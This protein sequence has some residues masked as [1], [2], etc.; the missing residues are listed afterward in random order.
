[1][2]MLC[3]GRKVSQV[4]TGPAGAETAPGGTTGQVQYNNAGAFG[5]TPKLTIGADAVNAAADTATPSGGSAAAFLQLGTTAGFGIYFGS[6]APT[7]SAAQGSIYLRTNGTTINNRAY[8][9]TGGT[10]WTG[11]GT[12]I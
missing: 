11:I 6:G 8:L 7:V 5:G 10:T 9:N 4:P 12:L 1:M 3:L 2:A